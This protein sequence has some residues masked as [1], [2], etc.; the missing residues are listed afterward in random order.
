MIH[1]I[2]NLCRIFEPLYKTCSLDDGT[3][4]SFFS[5]FLFFSSIQTMPLYFEAL[6]DKGH[7]HCMNPLNDVSCSRNTW[8]TGGILFGKKKCV[9][10]S[11]SLLI[12]DLVGRVLM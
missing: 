6:F 2:A 1:I 10:S 5:F 9:K 11:S 7:V 12:L 4:V 3:L 8:R